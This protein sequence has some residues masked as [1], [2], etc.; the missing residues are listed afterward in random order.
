M[1]GHR[2]YNPE[3]GRWISPDSIEYLDPSSINGLNLYCYCENDP[4]NMYDPDGHAPKWVYG[5]AWGIAAAA[6]VVAGVALM[7]ASGGS[8]AVA[9]SALTLAAS[10]LASSTTALTVASFAFIGTSMAFVGASMMAARS[11]NML[12]S[13]PS[14]MVSTL[15][16]GAYGAY[17]GYYS[18]NQQIGN[19]PSWSTIQKNYWKSKGYDSAPIG[20]DGYKIELNHPFGR[21]GSKINIFE[22]VT[23]TQH[24]QFHQMYGTGRGNGGFNQYYKFDNIWEWIRSVF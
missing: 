1:V 2:Y 5:L 14:V 6:V 15:T 8:A 9:L 24:V 17:G 16:A 4:V 7:V 20:S 23:H 10:G 13:G 3:W 11:G 21:Y 19:Q 18:W 22:E 12:E